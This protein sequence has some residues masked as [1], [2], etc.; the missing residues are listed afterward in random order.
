[1]RTA[2]VRDAQVEQQRLARGCRVFE[3]L[4]RGE[5]SGGRGS[6]EEE[7]QE[8]SLHTLRTMFRRYR[9]ARM[10][11]QIPTNVSAHRNDA[12]SGWKNGL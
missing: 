5:R 4:V 7:D 3:A 11:H 1:M 8:K 6:R 2:A 10:A 12:S 9:S